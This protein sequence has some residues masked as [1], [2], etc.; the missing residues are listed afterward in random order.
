[1]VSMGVLYTVLGEIAEKAVG[2]WNSPEGLAIFLSVIAV[3]LGI[4]SA[5]RATRRR[6]TI[7]H[8]SISNWDKD[9]IQSKNR[10]NELARHPE[11]MV[12]V[13]DVSKSNL[14]TNVRKVADEATANLPKK[15]TK[16]QAN[17]IKAVKDYDNSQIDLSHIRQILNHYELIAIGIRENI[18]DEAIYRRWFQT[19]LIRDW[20]A[21]SD[22]ISRLRKD[23]D[24][25][26][27]QSVYIEMEELATRWRAEGPLKRTVRHFRFAGRHIVIS[28]SR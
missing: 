24:V 6:A 12:A 13:Y 7:E 15:P 22:L 5:D 21:A 28:R 27:R 20:E 14:S 23:P 16:V 17:A 9:Y 1:M 4:A 10:F 11:S 26:N 18:I 19:G 2:I 3:L 25:P 8:L